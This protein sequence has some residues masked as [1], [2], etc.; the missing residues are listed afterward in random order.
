MTLQRQY[1]KSDLRGTNII[2]LKMR[3]VFP[4]RIVVERVDMGEMMQVQFGLKYGGVAEVQGRTPFE[5]MPG[6]TPFLD[7]IFHDVGYFPTE[8]RNF[9][10]TWKSCCFFVF[11]FMFECLHLLLTCTLTV[12]A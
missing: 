6:L 10:I 3:S 5:V 7:C 12:V 2:V 1:L 11:F 4:V 9:F 8:C